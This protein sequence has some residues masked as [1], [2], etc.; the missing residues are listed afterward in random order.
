MDQDRAEK[1][2]DKIAALLREAR[3]SQNAMRSHKVGHRVR[4]SHNVIG[5]G[6]T[7]VIEQQIVRPRVV[8]QPGEA[9]ISQPQARQLKDLVGAIVALERRVRP[10]PAGYQAVWGAL[11]SAMGVTRYLLIPRLRFCEARAFLVEWR[12][13]LA[14]QESRGESPAEA[15]RRSRIEYIETT[16]RKRGI[17][18]VWL[19]WM[20]FRFGKSGLGALNSD[21]LWVAYQHLQAMVAHEG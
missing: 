3:P 8:V 5:D 14:D 16:V 1:V 18:S 10:D 13:Y 2:T 4:G 20:T 17:E 19:P 6:N 11:N 7:I 9:H 12:A 15:A 21:D